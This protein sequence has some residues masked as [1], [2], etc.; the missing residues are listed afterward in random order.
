M[1][2]ANFNVTEMIIFIT[3]QSIYLMDTKCNLKSRTDIKDLR[4]I[5]LV[6]ANPCFF[7]LSYSNGSPPL[8]LQSFRRAEL[9]IYILSQRERTFPKPKIVVGDALRVFLKSGR[10]KLLEFDKVLK[11][12]ANL[13]ESQKNLL[14]TSQLNN[15]VN[16]LACGY[17]EMLQKGLFG[18]N[19]WTRYLVVLS[20]IGLLYFKDPLEPPADLFP[21]LNCILSSVDPEEVDN[22][23]TVFKL[24]YS[25][26]HVI[27][28]CGSLSEYNSWTKAI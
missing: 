18:G 24:E 17:L 9:M 19:K 15:F 28:R 6:K 23:T 10:T 16:A 1:Y 20:N 4:E 7:A 5:I 27:F 3:S 13:D 8:V 21:I 25:R 26:K 22:S 12:Q 2:N 14:E 11:S